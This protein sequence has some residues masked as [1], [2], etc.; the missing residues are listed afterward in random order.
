MG[1]ALNKEMAFFALLIGIFVVGIFGVGLVI[2]AFIGKKVTRAG[3]VRAII[4]AVLMA[5]CVIAVLMM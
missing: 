2:S 4:G 5:L 3:R 1:F